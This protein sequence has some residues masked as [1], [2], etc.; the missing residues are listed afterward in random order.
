MLVGA[1]ALAVLIL[2]L[3]PVYSAVF[4][5]D[6]GG[7]GDPGGVRDS[8]PGY[9]RDSLGA[10]Q[11]VAIRT[12]HGA[13]YADEAAVAAA[14]EP[15]FENYTRLHREAAVAGTGTVVN[16]TFDPDASGTRYGV[17]VVQNRSASL[18]KPVP[19]ATPGKEHWWVVRNSSRARL[20]WFTARL[21]V[22][23]LSESDPFVVEVENGS[24]EVELR[25]ESDGGSNDVSVRLTG[26]VGAMSEDVTCDSRAG[27]IV[28]DL[29]RGSADGGDCTFTGL[30]VLEG[31]VSVRFRNG[32]S[33]HGVYELVVRDGTGLQPTIEACTPQSPPPG[34]SN[35]CSSPTL[36][37]LSMTTTVRSDRTEYANRVNVSVYGEGGV[38]A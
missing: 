9:G 14:F 6:R 31:P 28:V 25:V 18:D 23:N 21:A 1:L 29:Y 17:R 19:G 7:V 26:D 22:S 33:A 16:A 12:G 35:P 5:T 2:A 38:S 36:W 27:E 24:H 4:T 10:A 20:G 30:D 8:V 3:V 34:L 11:Q 13:V 37:Q 15:A 32:S